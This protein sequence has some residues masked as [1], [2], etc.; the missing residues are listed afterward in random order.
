MKIDGWDPRIRSTNPSNIT[1]L[2]AC[3][4]GGKMRFAR[5]SDADT[6]PH[7][8]ILCSR[9]V[10]DEADATISMSRDRDGTM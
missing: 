4:Y 3:C 9:R 8:S 7:A 6:R 10:R 1:G 5:V 2:A